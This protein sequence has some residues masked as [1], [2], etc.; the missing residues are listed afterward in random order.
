M[1]RLNTITLMLFLGAAACT[2]ATADTVTV[3]LQPTDDVY[4]TNETPDAETTNFHYSPEDQ[5][6]L[7][8]HSYI[9]PSDTH[10][11]LKFSLAGIPDSATVTAATLHV[12]VIPTSQESVYMYRMADDAWSEAVVTWANYESSFSGGTYLDHQSVDVTGYAPAT[13]YA[14]DLA[15]WSAPGDLIDNS[16]TLMLTAYSQSTNYTTPAQMCSKEYTDAGGNHYA[17]Y[18]EIKYVP[19]PATMSLLTLGGLAML[20]RRRK[21]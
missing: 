3:Y 2:H 12:R 16:L 6:L 7:A 11:L 14:W 15:D 18:L 4:I 19:E 9:G 10:S 17:P 21:A 1:G 20:I 5:K 13:W 8:R